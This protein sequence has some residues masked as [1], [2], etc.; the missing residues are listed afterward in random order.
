MFSSIDLAAA[1]YIQGI[2]SNDNS[3]TW[4][5]IKDLENNAF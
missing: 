1:S 2:K 5:E 4:R 3:C